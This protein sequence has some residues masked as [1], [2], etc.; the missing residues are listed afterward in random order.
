MSSTTNSKNIQV[1]I[2]GGGVCGLTCAIALTK[3]GVPV[4]VYEAAAHF[5]EIGAGLGIGANAVKILFELGLVQDIVQRSEEADKER[6]SGWF[7]FLSGQEGHELI[8]DYPLRDKEG[9]IAIHR[10]AFL[11]ALVHYIDPQLVHFHKRCTEVVQSG[12]KVT[13]KFAD[14][15][16]ATADV[17]LGADGV[18]SAV[19]GAVLGKDANSVLSFSNTVCY[20][21][22]IPTELAQKSGVTRDYRKRPICYG[23]RW[24]DFMFFIGTYSPAHILW[25]INIVAFVA[26][27]DKAIGEEN[28]P[29]DAP[30]VVPVDTETLVKEYQGWG[31]EVTTLLSCAKEPSKWIIDVVHPPLQSYVKGRV[32]LLGDSA[33]AMLPHLGAGSGQGI[34]DAEMLTKLLSHPQ[35]TAQNVEEVLKAYDEVRRPRA[36]SVWEGSVRS[37]SIAD[38]H[39][40]SGTSKEALCKDLPGMWDFVWRHD[41]GA[42]VQQAVHTLQQRHVF[43]QHALM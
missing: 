5:G 19:R 36:Q 30:R 43:T 38:M 20:R 41:L 35:T 15:S 2:V 17:V 3:H 21:A 33:H 28:I 11:D 12:S 4:Q 13:I 23:E 42:D 24:S 31:N 9:S 40:P 32:A 37:G 18:K 22:L 25:Q 27:H 7:Q 6:P 8:Y 16:D 39:G 14:G 34:E 1:A 10:A 29:P 26:N